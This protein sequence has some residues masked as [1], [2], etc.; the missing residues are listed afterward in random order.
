MGT[1]DTKIYYS[2]SIWLSYNNVVNNW[3]RWGWSVVN[4]TCSMEN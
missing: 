4:S 3:R 1:F 2:R